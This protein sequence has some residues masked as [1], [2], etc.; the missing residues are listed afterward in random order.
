MNDWV[1]MIFAAL[2]PLTALFTVVQTNPYSALL[3]RGIMGVTA[4]MFYAVLGAAD[5]ALTEAL[6]GTLL[7]VILFAIAVRS[8][9]VMR[10][11]ML[12]AAEC[13]TNDFLLHRFCKIKKLSLRWTVFASE[14]ELVA[15][16]KAG[17]VDAVYITFNQVPSLARYFPENL[18]HDHKRTLLAEHCRWHERKIHELFEGELVDR[19]EYLK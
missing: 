5:V 10:V 14:K 16:F 17:K 3:S 4:I 19:L 7:T 8:S 18:D 1:L 6:V 11:G 13:P 12:G 15:A 9:L 2:L